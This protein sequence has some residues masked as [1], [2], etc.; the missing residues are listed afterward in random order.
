[1][2]VSLFVHELSGNPIVRAYPIA[3]AIEYLGHEV[4]V[5]GLTYNT[6][7]I[8]EPYKNEF[9]YKTVRS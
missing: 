9:E 2:K 7:K 1:M 3:K 5:L 8:Y 4:E 6:D